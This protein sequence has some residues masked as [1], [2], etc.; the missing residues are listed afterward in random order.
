[1]SQVVLGS[2]YG[3]VI[4]GEDLTWR[5][6]LGMILI[7]GCGLILTLKPYKAI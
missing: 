3:V 7:L 2:T 5:L 6:I 1:M 4:L